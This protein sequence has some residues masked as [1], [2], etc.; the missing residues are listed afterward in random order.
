[1]DEWTHDTVANR[2]VRA[3]R[4][5]Q[6]LPAVRVQS[7]FNLWPVIVRTEFERLATEES[8][9]YR[10]PPSPADIDDLLEVMRWMNWLSVDE[11]LLLWMRA[12]RHPWNDIAKRF[13][14]SRSTVCRQWKATVQK[15]V[16]ILNTSHVL[17][18]R[19]MSCGNWRVLT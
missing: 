1:M 11:R 16:L 3:S 9:V 19:Q 13:G 17:Q 7:H 12:D 8:G 14:Y 2:I 10:S 4:T 5:A 18:G 6:R 15:L